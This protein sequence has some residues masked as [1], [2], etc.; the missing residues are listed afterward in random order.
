MY[1]YVRVDLRTGMLV[2]IEEGCHSPDRDLQ[3][4]VD[5]IADGRIIAP[6]IQCFQG[7]VDTLGREFAEDGFDIVVCHT[8]QSRVATQH[9]GKMA[10][11]FALNFF[12]EILEYLFSFI[13]FFPYPC[14][15]QI[16]RMKYI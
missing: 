10:V 1:R 8:K 5:T 12:S 9:Q 16:T 3:K 6:M 7:F 14:K 15:E 4:V 13:F 11:D 2:E